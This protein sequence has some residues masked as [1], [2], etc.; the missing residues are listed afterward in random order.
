[1]SIISVFYVVIRHIKQSRPHTHTHAYTCHRGL[2]MSQARSVCHRLTNATCHSP[3]A[4]A[5]N[6]IAPRRE[7]G[8]QDPLDPLTK[9][10]S[11][12]WVAYCATTLLEG[13]ME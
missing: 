12:W 8:G 11:H 4:G 3:H 6:Q 9:P 2:R 7:S 10:S 1:M 13:V 5:V